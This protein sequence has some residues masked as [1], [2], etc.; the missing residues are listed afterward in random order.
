METLN[1]GK[2]GITTE[3]KV[4]GKDLTVKTDIMEI[5]VDIEEKR[6]IETIIDRR[7]MVE[8]DRNEG[9]QETEY[10]L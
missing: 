9:M 3:M 7:E 2:E 5:T 1:I 6:A 10:L 8:M 4:V